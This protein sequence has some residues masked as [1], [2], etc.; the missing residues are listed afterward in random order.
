MD[1]PKLYEVLE[2]KVYTELKKRAKKRGFDCELK[3]F[4]NKELK[5]I[6]RLK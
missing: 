2:P 3:Y 5:R 6:W 4:L 1:N